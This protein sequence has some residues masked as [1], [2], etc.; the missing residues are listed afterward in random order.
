MFLD[1]CLGLQKTTLA[2]A[3]NDRG[4]R[5]GISVVIIGL[6]VFFLKK[7][8]VPWQTLEAAGILALFAEIKPRRL[9]G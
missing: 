5:M 2:G 9:A 6:Q 1:V 4:I 8:D 7:W 3:L